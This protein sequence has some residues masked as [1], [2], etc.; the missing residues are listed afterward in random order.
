MLE[1][2]LNK[3]TGLR[4]GTLLK[5]TPTQVFFSEHCET[6]QDTLFEEQLRTAVTA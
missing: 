2:F 3:E 1:S 5:E 4:P 6:F